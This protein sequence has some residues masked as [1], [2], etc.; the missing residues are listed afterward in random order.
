MIKKLKIQN[1]TPYELGKNLFGQYGS[2]QTNLS[3]TYKKQFKNK[4]K[5]KFNHSH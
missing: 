2:G 3:T 5:L 4:L 1:K